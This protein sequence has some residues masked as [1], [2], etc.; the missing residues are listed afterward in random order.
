MTGLTRYLAV[1][2]FRDSISL[3]RIAWEGLVDRLAIIDFEASCL[4]EHGESF[5]IEVALVRVGGPARTWLI[6][7]SVKWRY[8]DWSEEA[9]SLHGISRDML[10]RKGVP[11]QQVLSELAEAGSGC[12][13]YADSDLDAYWLETLAQA[14]NR[15][16]PFPILYLGELFQEMKTDPRAIARAEASAL[17][18]LPQ[19]HIACKDARRLALAVELL[20]AA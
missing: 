15:L 16:A 1:Q 4:P 8:W 9:E 3:G 18:R 7:P 10:A 14:C 19:Q 20:A 5:P 6:R 13:V 2:H 12:R 11:P 17:S